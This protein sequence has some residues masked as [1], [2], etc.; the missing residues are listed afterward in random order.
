MS[1]S[2]KE[3]LT[4][5]IPKHHAWK[6]KLIDQWSDIFGSLSSNVFPVLIKDT[7]L[8]IGVTHP[9]WAQELYMLEATFKAKINACTDG[10]P[11]ST[12]SFRV[13]NKPKQKNAHSAV[14]N[15]N[16]TVLPEKCLLLSSAEQKLLT[17]IR[18][19]EFKTA[20]HQFLARCKLKKGTFS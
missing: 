14:T 3:L 17:T 1:R 4:T 12:I 8:V 10:H 5:I 7:T 13:M 9:I 2:I 18:D 11:I 15:T 16:Q 19:E 20:M 6:I